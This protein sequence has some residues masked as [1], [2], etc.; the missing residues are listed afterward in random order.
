[1]IYL[2]F[3]K[4]YWWICY[5]V[6]E[7]FAKSSSTC[8][9][10]YSRQRSFS[11]YKCLDG[12]Y[13]QS[14]HEFVFNFANQKSRYVFFR[15]WI[16]YFNFQKKIN[17]FFYILALLKTLADV[18]V[19]AQTKL[20]DSTGKLVSVKATILRELEKPISQISMNR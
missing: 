11:S 4:Y 18:F 13:C 16:H 19:N 15:L 8:N 7:I 10:I 14:L 3:Q 12:R 17:I 20:Y 6:F 9:V 2:F 5:Y 1:M